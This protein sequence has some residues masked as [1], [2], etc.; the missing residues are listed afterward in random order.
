MAL[1]HF[2]SPPDPKRCHGR[3]K[4]LNKSKMAPRIRGSLRWLSPPEYAVVQNPRQ[5]IND[6]IFEGRLQAQDAF[7]VMIPGSGRE[8]LA[9][10]V[11]LRDAKKDER[12]QIL[13][14]L[15]TVPLNYS[16]T[17][18]KSYTWIIGIGP[19]ILSSNGWEIIMVGW[20]HRTPN[21]KSKY[22]PNLVGTELYGSF[23]GFLD[24]QWFSG[25]TMDFWILWIHDGFLNSS[26]DFSI[27]NVFLD[28]QWIS[29]FTMDFWILDGFW[30]RVHKFFLL[31]SYRPPEPL[32]FPGGFQPPRPPGGR[33][34]GSPRL[35][36]QFWRGSTYQALR[37]LRYQNLG[38]KIS[39]P[40]CWTNIDNIIFLSPP[41]NEHPLQSLWTWVVRTPNCRTFVLFR[42]VH[43]K[44]G[45]VILSKEYWRFDDWT[46][47]IS[48]S[49]WH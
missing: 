10:A 41:P 42:G 25:F 9:T 18:W 7:K 26:I 1:D 12:T 11:K 31:R 36:V 17:Q 34:C 22:G 45:C 49:A 24:S 20:C 39:E 5:A 46:S 27:H 32:L 30:F 15:G 40:S 37:F 48:M 16:P 43:S 2:W 8:L 4:N 38:T 44:W 33:V 35:F 6:N 19:P 14:E 28:S 47:I 3:T 29:G 13:G 23:N 21:M